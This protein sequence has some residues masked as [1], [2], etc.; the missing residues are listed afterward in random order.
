MPSRSSKLL[1][2]LLVCRQLTSRSAILPQLADS[3][4]LLYETLCARRSH[5]I[6][7]ASLKE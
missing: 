3:D 6:S 5:A 1:N 2:L 4:Q 7:E